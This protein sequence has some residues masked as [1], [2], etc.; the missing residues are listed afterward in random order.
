MVGTSACDDISE[1]SFITGSTK[2]IKSRKIVSLFR[3]KYFYI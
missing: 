3:L 1:I 2:A